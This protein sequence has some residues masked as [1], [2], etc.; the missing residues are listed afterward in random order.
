MIQLRGT[1]NPFAQCQ[2]HDAGRLGELYDN[3]RLPRNQADLK[4]LQ[5]ASAAA[6]QRYGAA[7]QTQRFGAEPWQ[8]FD[9]FRPAA[10]RPASALLFVHGGRWQFNSSRETAFWADAC[11]QAGMLFI[12]LN[13]RSLDPGGLPALVDSVAR[14]VAAAVDFAGSMDLDPSALCLAGHSSGAHLA[15]AALLP[16]DGDA[17]PAFAWQLGGLLL[18][19]GMYD[20]APLRRTVHQ[21]VLRFS[22]EDALQGSP[23]HVL[24]RAAAHG[25]RCELPPTLVAVGAQES[26]EYIRQSRA[27]HWALQLHASAGWR[28]VPGAA[29]FDAALEFNQADSVLRRFAL[30]HE[31]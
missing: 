5:A 22:E 4:T 7:V 29:H 3:N 25:Q 17:P 2:V 11:C 1:P 6:Y 31:L 26:T 8:A 24:M 12:G 9:V 27:L 14:A 13:F 16:R 30:Q 18:L 19:G 21:Q 10:A 20:L 23:I 15:L 28:E